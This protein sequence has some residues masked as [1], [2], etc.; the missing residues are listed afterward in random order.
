MTGVSKAVISVALSD[1]GNGNIRVSKS[2]REKIRALAKEKGYVVNHAARQLTMRRS[3]MWGVLCDSRPSE[4]NAMRLALLHK[5]A[6]NK[7]YRVVVEYYDHIQPDLDSLL[8]VF[9]NLGVEGVICLHHFF[10][11][12]HSLIPRLLTKH[13]ERV[14]FIDRPK[15]SKPCFCGVDYVEVGRM[16]YQA[17]R[18]CGPRPGLLLKNRLWYSGPLLAKGFMDAWEKDPSKGDHPPVWTA[19]A[20]GEEKK[21]LFDITTARQALDQWALPHKLTGLAVWVD[22]RATLVVNA[23][24]EQGLSVP[25]DMAVIGIGNARICELIRPTLSSVDLQI[26]QTIDS[27]VEMLYQLCQNKGAPTKILI[28]PRL[29][30][31]QSSPP[32]EITSS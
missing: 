7:D 9:Q 24:Q 5:A 27:A 14:V 6:R 10:P 20:P 21:P 17:L 12:Q 32:R 26:E 19:E 28:E 8:E 30:L 11:N 1:S 2:L 25:E 31:R 18:Q 15:I 29:Q 3:K 22:E 4:L 16:A 13:F 23:L